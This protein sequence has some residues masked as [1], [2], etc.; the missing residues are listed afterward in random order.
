MNRLVTTDNGGFPFVLDDLRW[1]LSTD[2]AGLIEAFSSMLRSIS[3]NM[4]LDGCVFSGDIESSG[5]ITA[6]WIM[7]DGEIIKVDAQSGLVEPNIYFNKVDTFDSAG[8]KQFEDATF[9]DTYKKTRGVITSTVSNL[10]Y[11]GSTLSQLI[12]RQ[13]TPTQTGMLETSTNAE[14]QAGTDSSKAVTPSS[15]SSRTATE[16]RTGLAELATTAEATAGTDTERIV[17][18]AGLQSKLSA[19]YK[20]TTQLATPGAWTDVSSSMEAGWSGTLQY[21]IDYLGFIHIYAKQIK[22]SSNITETTGEIIWDMSGITV[23]ITPEFITDSYD[24]GGAENR[25]LHVLRVNPEGSGKGLA[26]FPEPNDYVANNDI[27]FYITFR[28]DS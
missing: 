11:N 17:T 15:L 16:T 26:I 20:S 12:F 14:T 3:E 9:H 8:N 13:A 25:V 28:L 1:V 10:Q 7:L 24:S 6:G 5:A 23:L 18:P 21:F 27:S 22:K 2:D 19:E 4:I